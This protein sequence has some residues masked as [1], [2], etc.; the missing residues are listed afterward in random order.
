[1]PLPEAVPVD[2]AWALPSVEDMAGVERPMHQSHD[3]V[4]PWLSACQTL[5]QRPRG[6]AHR[7]ARGAQ[8]AAPGAGLL[9]PPPLPPR[10]AAPPP[11]P[12]SLS[13]RAGIARAR[14]RSRIAISPGSRGSWGRSAVGLMRPLRSLR[15]LERL[16]D[17]APLLGREH[18]TGA[19]ERPPRALAPHVE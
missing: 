14:P 4:V 11:P 15:R 6:T 19:L 5:C 8:R 9:P 13:P 10:Q 3:A 2:H 12:P 1:R 7:Q 17:L 16:G 18:G